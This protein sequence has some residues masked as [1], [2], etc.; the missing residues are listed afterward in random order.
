LPQKIISIVCKYKH[1]TNYAV[2]DNKNMDH[3]SGETKW[4]KITGAE[5]NVP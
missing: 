2:V 1:S 5:G 4:W 3:P